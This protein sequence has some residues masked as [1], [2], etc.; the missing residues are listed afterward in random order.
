MV[1]RP[2]SRTSSARNFAGDQAAIDTLFSRSERLF[3]QLDGHMNEIQM[4]FRT[5]TDLDLGP[6][7]PYDETFA[8]YDP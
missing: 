7:L 4:A 3:E 8:G 1:T 6:I 5:Q 2:L